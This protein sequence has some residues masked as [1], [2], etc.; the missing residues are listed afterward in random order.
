MA[1]EYL[2]V[3]YTASSSS[4]VN[5]G[6]CPY[7]ELQN[8]IVDAQSAGGC[9]IVCGDMNARSETAEQDASCSHMTTLDLLTFGNLLMSQRREHTWVLMF[10]TGATVMSLRLPLLALGEMSCWSYVGLLN[11]S[12]ST[13][14]HLETPQGG[15][16]SPALR[17]KYG[18]L[19]RCVCTPFVISD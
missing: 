10:P 12:S 7:D 3:C 6:I 11:Y 13:D 9:I 14:G 1:D 2:C 18:G 8:D 5:T 19:L 17:A 4:T 16:L 15:I